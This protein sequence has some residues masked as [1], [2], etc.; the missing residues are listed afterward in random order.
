MGAPRCNMCRRFRSYENPEAEIQSIDVN[1]NDEIVVE[2]NTLFFCGECGTE[3]GEYLSSGT[4]PH[5][6]M[7]CCDAPEP[8][9][10]DVTVEEVIEGTEPK[11][12]RRW[13]AVSVTIEYDCVCGMHYRQP[14][15]LDTFYTREIEYTG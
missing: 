15:I 11:T 1:D 7:M 13:F 5:D 10:L 4:E 6:E 8:I 12:H 14:T 2:A 3:L 9:N